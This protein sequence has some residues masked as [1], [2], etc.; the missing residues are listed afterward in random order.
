MLCP[1]ASG[2]VAGVPDVPSVG[3]GFA[4]TPL[5]TAY[6]TSLQFEKEA[7]NGGVKGLALNAASV[8]SVD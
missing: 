3:G 8:H 1:T 2:R 5:L 6:L 7:P 4:A